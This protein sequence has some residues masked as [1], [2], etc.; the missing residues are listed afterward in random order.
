MS[1]KDYEQ[2]LTFGQ[3]Y[4]STA[5]R[6]HSRQDEGIAYFFQ[7]YTQKR[8]GNYQEAKVNLLLAD[9]LI[10]EVQYPFMG[11]VYSAMADLHIAQGNLNEALKKL[12]QAAEVD[13]QVGFRY[14]EGTYLLQLAEIY[15]QRGENELAIAE[16]EAGLNKTAIQNDKVV[17][18]DLLEQ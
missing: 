13:R 18:L 2:M 1:L 4:L 8:L 10:S 11:I 5:Q 17:L 9:N 3:Q 6:F 16:L 15:R 14:N 12:N 7:G